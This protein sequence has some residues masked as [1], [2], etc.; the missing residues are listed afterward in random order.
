MNY[1]RKIGIVQPK[2]PF[3]SQRIFLAVLLSSAI[4]LS[5]SISYNP[6]KE[7]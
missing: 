3:N 7:L 6:D 2:H 1:P 4:L 5:C